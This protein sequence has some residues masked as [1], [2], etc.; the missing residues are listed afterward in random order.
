MNTGLL[1][2]AYSPCRMSPPDRHQ[3]GAVH[4]MR[5]G[6]L[7]YV[8]FFMIFTSSAA[9]AK[10]DYETVIDK[11]KAL[12]QQPYAAPPPI[13]KFLQELTFTQYQ[14]IRFIPEKS[15]WRDNQ[16]RFQVM[17]V[18]P[19][20]YYTHAVKINL[21][22]AAGV[23]PLTIQKDYFSFEL[24][25]GGDTEKKIPPGL[26]FAGIKLTFHFES[27]EVQNQFMVFAGASKNRGNSTNNTNDNTTHDNTNDTGLPS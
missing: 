14:G 9:T 18:P 10:F 1:V 7:G 23:R 4:N 24:G 2:F 22:D 3:Q 11:A 8:I 25:D 26:G 15:L 6:L 12:A 19:W 17:L 5:R 21:V 16:S 27:R 13:P 20:L